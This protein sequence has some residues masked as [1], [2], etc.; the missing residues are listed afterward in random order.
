MGWHGS[1]GIVP[2][3]RRPWAHVPDNADVLADVPVKLQ[4]RR[5]ALVESA[6][7]DGVQF[8]EDSSEV[9][10]SDGHADSST[11]TDSGCL[12][13]EL[14]INIVGCPVDAKGSSQTAITARATAALSTKVWR[15]CAHLERRWPSSGSHA[16]ARSP[17][18]APLPTFGGSRLEA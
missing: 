7:A 9:L 17:K 13:P 18:P 14:V 1:A 4:T 11:P 5:G 6:A 8:S 15:N 12:A 3:L 2:G 16:L 10:R